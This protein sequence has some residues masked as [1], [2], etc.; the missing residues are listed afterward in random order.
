MN[1]FCI[2]GRLVADPVLRGQN[3]R[4]VAAFR[5]AVNRSHHREGQPTADFF[6]VSAFGKTAEFV[7]KYFTKG[8]PIAISG[9]LRIEEYQSRDGERRSQ[10][11][12]YAN[13][14]D[15]CGSRPEGQTQTT[16]AHQAYEQNQ[17]GTTEYVPTDGVGGDFP[18]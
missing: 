13:T 11:N 3:E 17:N 12:L 1:N 16:P 9:E 10:P 5:V 2:T 15:F 8:S 4:Q 14:V 7:Q 18:F 6:Q